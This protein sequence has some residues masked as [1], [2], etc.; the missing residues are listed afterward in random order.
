MGAKEMMV[1]VDFSNQCICDKIRVYVI[2][3]LS[4]CERKHLLS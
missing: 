4:R 1:R 2:N 3:K